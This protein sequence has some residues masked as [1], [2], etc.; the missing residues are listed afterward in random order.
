M[1]D[2]HASGS[3]AVV[4]AGRPYHTDPF[5]SHGIS[6]MF[7]EAGIP[8]LTADSL[9]RQHEVPL[10]DVLVEITNN[11]HTR[12]LESALIAANDPSLEYAQ[13]VS[14]GCGHDAILSDE[15][16]RILE[17]VGNKHPLIL[18]VDESEAQGSIAIRV[19]SFMETMKG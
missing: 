17:T 5:V 19:R 11:F 8:V 13:I 2:V 14:F 6:R 1:R 10:A 3:K 18:K 16:T 7:A 4:L 9:P 12:M 15:I